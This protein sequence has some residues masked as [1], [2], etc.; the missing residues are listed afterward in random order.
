MLNKPV[1]T[2]VAPEQRETSRSAIQRKTSG[3]QP[4]QPFEREYTRRDGTRLILEVHENFVRDGAGRIVGIRSLLLNVT[5]RRKSEQELLE[6][7]RLVALSS[8]ISIALVQEES[9]SELLRCCTEA[10][11]RHLDPAFARVWTYNR[12]LNVLELQASSGMY[13]HLDGPHGVVPV[14][15]FKIGLIAQHRQPHVTNAVI[16]DPRV[17][18]QEW[19]KREKMVAFAGYPLT[20]G[21]ELVGVMAMFSRQ[22]ISEVTLGSMASVANAIALGIKRKQAEEDLLRSRQLFES[23]MN[24]SPA[25]AFMKDELGRYVYVNGPWERLFDKDRSD[26]QGKSDLELWPTQIAE[27]LRRNDAAVLASDRSTELEE[28]VLKDGLPRHFLVLKFPFH[29]SSARRFLGGMAVD[30]TERKRAE[31]LDQD[32]RQV[33]ELVARN[34]PL[35]AVLTYLAQLVERQFPDMHCSVSLLREGHLHYGAAPSLSIEYVRSVHERPVGPASGSCGT[36]AYWGRNVIV[37]DLATDPLFDEAREAALAEGLRACCSVPVFSAA[38][39][40][41]GTVTAYYRRPRQPGEEEIR[42]LET[43]GQL[44]AL[45]IEHR[46]LTDQLAYQADHDTLTGLPNRSLFQDRLRQ[47]ILHADR[48]GS[49][50]AVF[51]IDLDRFKLIND[52]LGH[53]LGDVLLQ[54]V[55]TRLRSCVRRADT[56]ARMGG[57]EFTLIAPEMTDDQDARV[58]AQNLMDALKIPFEV[59]GYELFVTPSIGISLYPQD[60]QDASS[61]QRNADI[62]M[63]RVKNQGK[64]NFECFAAEIDAAGPERLELQ[65]DLYRALDRGELQ[66]YFQPQFELINCSLVGFET[67]LRWNHSR[68]GMISPGRFV[69]LAE[70]SGLIVPIGE[71]VLNQACEQSLAWQRSGFTPVRIAVNVSAL[72]FARPDFNDTVAQA[73]ARSGLEPSLLELELTESVVMRNVEESTNKMRRLRSIGVRIA[74]DDFGTGY[75]SLSYLQRLT[76]DVLKIDLSFVREIKSARQIPPLIQAIVGLGHGLGLE[77]TAEG[78]EN[79]EQLEALRFIGCDI[80]QGYLLGRPVPVLEAA[81]LLILD[82]ARVPTV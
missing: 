7:K 57:D 72:Q 68:L 51:N 33:V 3:E 79:E 78:V 23:F 45:A 17:S 8:D 18:N 40:V 62:A 44:A 32:R 5:Q 13:T 35:E 9:P 10:L 56:L 12:D 81:R 37:G 66:L 67:L 47:A 50:L 77:V 31:L 16:G 11:V 73:L 60:A 64:N 22:P 52:T 71:W 6:G 39:E 19:A 82:E 34:E 75:S 53:T 69:P 43:A 28:T 63:Y 70:E 15:Q 42:L 46:Q 55:A 65:T 54:E 4:L 14:G 1:W 29:D 76:I 49:M 59:G 80:G 21:D 30:I 27:T 26:W 2:F 38:G 41:L 25:V 61:L 24:N 36:A 58:L 74:I 20:W 48:Y